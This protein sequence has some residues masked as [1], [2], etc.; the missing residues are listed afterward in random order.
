MAFL[1][2]HVAFKHG[3]RFL[4][5]GGRAA[6]SHFTVGNSDLKGFAKQKFTLREVL[7]ECVFLFKLDI[8]DIS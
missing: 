5:V 7:L 8:Y 1:R 4:F 3:I 6:E 2:K